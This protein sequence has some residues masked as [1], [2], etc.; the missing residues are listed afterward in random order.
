MDFLVSFYNIHYINILNNVIIGNCSSYI[1]AL[2][3]IF[4]IFLL[5]CQYKK[6]FSL[7]ELRRKNPEVL[8]VISAF[9]II[10]IVIYKIY[11]ENQRYNKT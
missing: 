5:S 10:N 4:F 8:L 9:F 7:L 6:N 3:V 2:L 11:G 1:N